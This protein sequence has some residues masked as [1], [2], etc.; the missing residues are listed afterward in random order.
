[1]RIIKQLAEQIE[2]EACGALEYAKDA[3]EYK[4][5]YPQLS[6]V[7]YK[8]ANT[9]YEHATALHDQVVRIIENIKNDKKD[10]PDFMMEKWEK[11]HSKLIEKIAEAKIYLGIYK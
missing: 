7:Y 9:E 4:Y 11:K 5:S 6:E 3:I 10:I 8:L 2:D 1:M